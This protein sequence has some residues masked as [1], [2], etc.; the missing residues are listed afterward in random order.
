MSPNQISFVGRYI[1]AAFD[2]DVGVCEEVIREQ[3]VCMYKSVEMSK[4]KEQ[5]LPST[6]ILAIITSRSPV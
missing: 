1:C 2:N 3:A 5:I 4:F 6:L